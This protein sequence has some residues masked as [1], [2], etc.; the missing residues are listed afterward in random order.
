MNRVIA[1]LWLVSAAAGAG[2]YDDCILENLKGVTDRV[3]VYEVKAACRHK[4]LPYVPAKCQPDP[5][6]VPRTSLEL[7]LAALHFDVPCALL[8]T[9][10]NASWWSKHFGEC[11]P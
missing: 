8:E 10:L 7:K 6:Y 11:R 1:V 3:A 5:D 2:E 4:A 9:C